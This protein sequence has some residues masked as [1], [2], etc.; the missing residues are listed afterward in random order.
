MDE[1]PS[2]YH[3][4]R[5]YESD[6]VEPAPRTVKPTRAEKFRQSGGRAPAIV[7]RVITT[8]EFA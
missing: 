8:P 7:G 1:F 4:R 6:E 3:H 5:G 2:Q